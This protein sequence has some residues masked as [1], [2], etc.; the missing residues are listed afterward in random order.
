[1]TDPEREIEDNRFSVLL[2]GIIEQ[3]PFLFGGTPEQRPPLPEHLAFFQAAFG[4]TVFELDVLI[5]LVILNSGFKHDHFPTRASINQ[6]R[7]LGSIPTSEF[8]TFAAN[9]ALLKWEMIQFQVGSAS[10]GLANREFFLSDWVFHTLLGSRSLGDV[11]EPVLFLDGGVSH[12]LSQQQQQ[13][14]KHLGKYVTHDAV[15]IQLHGRDASLQVDLTRAIAEVTQQPLYVLSVSALAD[16]LSGRYGVVSVSHLT[17]HWNRF[18]RVHQALLLVDVRDLLVGEGSNA[19]MR[20]LITFIESLEGAVVVATREPLRLT[21]REAMTHEVTTPIAQEQREFWSVQLRRLA[22][23]WVD[24]EITEGILLDAVEDFVATFNFSAAQI[25]GVLETSK[26]SFDAAQH[27]HL[28]VEHVLERLFKAVREAGCELSRPKFA[29]LTQLLRP[30][31]NMHRDQLVMEPNERRALDDMLLHIRKRQFVNEVMGW[32]RNQ[33][34]GLAIAAIFSGPSGTGKTFA[35]QILAKELGLDLQVIDASSLVSKYIGESEKNLSKVFDAAEAGGCILFFD[36]GENLFGKRGEIEG[37][38]D[39]YANQ[40]VSYLLQRLEAYR[41]IVI[42]TTNHEGNIDPAF[43][44]RFRF[45]IRFR[46]PEALERE[47]IWRN[48]F[49][50]DAPLGIKE[51]HYKLLASFEAPGGNIINVAYSAC[52]Y[53]AHQGVSVK[54]GHLEKAARDEVRKLKRLVRVGEFDGWQD[55]ADQRVSWN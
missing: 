35:G 23:A 41:G 2:T 31:P 49:P 4:L 45:V 13:L 22:G 50:S 7:M 39:R 47:M 36:E 51:H 8:G 42:I 33:S 38:N 37:G 15:L 55:D 29:G 28:G 32:D 16:A 20:S 24:D 6:F 9:G 18:A 3:Q 25:A 46:L 21:K 11:L 48:I 52:V 30:A 43:L 44:R 27:I 26:I 5:A 34:K 54:M 19:L 40:E 14:V 10:I 17:L 1:M 12:P 53:A